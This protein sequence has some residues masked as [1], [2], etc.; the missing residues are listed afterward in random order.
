M[1]KTQRKLIIR[2]LFRHKG[3]CISM[4]IVAMLAVMAYLGINETAQALKNNAERFWN[5]TKFRDIE[6]TAPLLLSEEDMD[7]I[8]NT[9]GVYAVEPVW[10][11]SAHS[12]SGKTAEFDIVS[13]TENIN[14]VRLKEGRMPQA[15]DE[16]L[17]ESPLIEELGI[18]VGDVL[19][20]E[21]DENLSVTRFTVCGTGEH[22]EHPCLPFHVPGNRYVIVQKEAFDLEGMENCCMKAVL[23]TEAKD[24][25]RFSREYHDKNEEVSKRLISLV[26][27]N[28]GQQITEDGEEISPKT[29]LLAIA[30]GEENIKPWLVFDS[31]SSTYSYA[32][33]SCAENVAVIGKTF[34]LMF[35][36]VG[37]LV[38]FASV[39]RMAEEDKHEIGN[40]KASGMTK[41]EIALKYI[42]AGEIPTAAGMVAGIIAG[43][44][45]VQPIL[46]GIYGG[47]YVYGKGSPV[48]LPFLSLTVFIIG[49]FIVAVS[50]AIAC[51][52]LVAKPARILLN[53]RA[54]PENTVFKKKPVKK[55]RP[56]EHKHSLYVRMIIRQ[57]LREKGRLLVIVISI[58]GT[59]VLLI[60]GF[61]IRLSVAKSVKKQFSEVELYNLKVRFEEDTDNQNL[62]NQ[63]TEILKAA[64]LAENAPDE[65]WIEAVNRDCVFFAD[66]RMNGGELI[67][68]EP[69]KLKDYF[70]V[71][72]LKG[73]DYL[74]RSDSAGLLIPLRTSETANINPGEKI[75]MFDG[76][77]NLKN[78]PVE[79]M[80]KN[81]VGG[82]ML[83]TE[84]AYE[85]IYQ[86]KPEYNCFLI[87]C[88]DEKTAVIKK[89]LE[90]LP[91]TVTDMKTK[92][93]EYLGYAAALKTVAV[94]LI[95]LAALMAGGVLI[96][97]IYLQYY[98]KKRSLVI[99][100]INGFTPIKTAGYVLG[101]SVVTHIIGMILGIAGGSWFSLRI[102][103]IVESRLFY[104]IRSPQPVAW[105]L[106][107]AVMLV[108]SF[109]IHS[110]IVR[111]IIKLKPT[112]DVMIR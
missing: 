79:G 11:A 7:A 94:L 23:K 6:I 111:S 82:Q 80:F 56:S 26:V 99:M 89:Y 92:E 87:K 3:A 59:M 112:E 5:E 98:R 50:A 104:I 9:E 57:I 64:G 91:V 43:Y 13:Q 30:S 81:Y 71:K 60:T 44:A 20:V 67:C 58:A 75:L 42:L 33:F 4:F 96:N 51:I 90:N 41:H 86:E 101:E 32:I 16:C 106:A 69:E 2:Y 8:R 93:E 18:S 66:G 31:L 27:K 24:Y 76:A 97:L 102:L 68:A 77:T 17:I 34:A 29:I 61:T 45:V 28:A 39:S 109:M 84:D 62:K 19:E 25:N 85:K 100:R 83:L 35:V 110:V 108:F 12:V 103:R 14:M 54:L 10:Y 1:K 22:A 36:I 48:F 46:L 55:K 107:A 49:L 40:L 47:F 37:A 52:S 73:K 65:G 78:V 63:I 72:D 70:A 74:D 53:D 88:G 95:G 38:I 21:S 105:L 15:P